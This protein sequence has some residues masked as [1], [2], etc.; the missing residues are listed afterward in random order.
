MIVKYYSNSEDLIPV[1]IPFL[2][3]FLTFIF[4]VYSRLPFNCYFV[5]DINLESL[6]SYYSIYISHYML[7]FLYSQ[8]LEASKP[9][10]NFSSI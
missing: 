2:L 6:D 1:T 4:A 10:A 5:G 9:P 7:F 8:V 3:I